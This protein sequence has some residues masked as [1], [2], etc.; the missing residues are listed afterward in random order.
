[1]VIDLLTEF[2]DMDVGKACVRAVLANNFEGSDADFV[3]SLRRL[4][5]APSSLGRGTSKAGGRLS[6]RW[7][8]PESN[9]K[10]RTRAD[11]QVLE[12]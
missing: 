5:A 7:R 8:W 12:A 6:R 9:R 1:M 11:P 10:W 2:P 3:N 4:G